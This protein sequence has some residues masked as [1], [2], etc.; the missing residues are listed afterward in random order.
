MKVELSGTV[1]R[2]YIDGELYVDFDTGSPAEA[3]AY[4]VVSTDET[5]DVIVKIVNVTGSSKTLSVNVMN[6]D[7]A[8]AADVEQLRGESLGDD[9]ILGQPEDCK[10]EAFEVDGISNSFNYTVPAYSVTVI[11][12][13]K[14]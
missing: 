11:R 12:L 2:C 13:H 1:V 5:G 4:H 7:I 8:S 10:V 6:A 9:N 3:E 14:A